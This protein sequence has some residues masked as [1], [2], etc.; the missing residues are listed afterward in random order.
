MLFETALSL[1][2]GGHST[3]RQSWTDGA[4]SADPNDSTNILLT[5]STGVTTWVPTNPD[6]LATDWQPGD[7]VA[8][9]PAPTVTPDPAPV[10]P[11]PTTTTTKGK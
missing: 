5:A 6:L 4:I 7:A 9:T 1:L 3:N 2:R 11:T 10:D 8:Q